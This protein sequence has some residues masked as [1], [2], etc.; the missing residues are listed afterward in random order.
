MGKFRVTGSMRA[1]GVAVRLA[2]VVVAL[3]LAVVA[4]RGDAPLTV[5]A[6]I[7]LTDSL[8]AVAREYEKSGGNAVRFNFAASNVLSRQI[9]NGAPVDLFISADEKQMDV[10]ADAGAIDVKTRVALLGNRLAIVT[11]PGGPGISDSRALLQ[12]DFRRIAIG[13]PTGVPAGVYAREYLQRVGI[14]EALLPKLVPVS[15]VRAALASVGNGSTD[16][17]FIYETDAVGAMN[18]S[19]AL[20]ISGDAAPR[21][22]YPAA[23]MSRAPNRAAAEHLLAYLRGPAAAAVFARYK[24]VPLG[25]AD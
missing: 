17:A 11:R 8:Q 24:F 3:L 21:I 6:A 20:V 12:L 9:V 1:W 22:V 4:G 13:D 19:A 10:A 14:W 18:V 15:N 2:V 16:A 7:S 23:I 5:S 25:R